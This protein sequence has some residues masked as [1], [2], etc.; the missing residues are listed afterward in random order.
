MSVMKRAFFFLLIALFLTFSLPQQAFSS[1]LEDDAVL[2]SPYEK[3]MYVAD[4][5]ESTGIPCTRHTDSSQENGCFPFNITVDIQGNIPR[6]KDREGQPAKTLI[7]SFTQDF[8]E[9]NPGFFLTLIERI[10]N[11]GL[12][13]S[14]TLLFSTE[15]ERESLPISSLTPCDT[16]LF[17]RLCYENDLY[18]SIV[19]I[20][21]TIIQGKILTTGGRKQSPLWIV[22]LIKNA[23]DGNGKKSRV[24][25]QF[26]HKA[27]HQSFRE[28]RRLSAFLE[29]DICAAGLPLGTST[30]D[31]D[32]LMEILNEYDPDMEQNWTSHYNCI[33][34]MGL[35]IW[36]NESFLALAFMVLSA[37]VLITI[38]FNSFS[39]STKNIATMQDIKRTFYF[40]PAYVAISVLSITICQLGFYFLRYRPMVYFLLKYGVSLVLI[41]AVIF[42]QILFRFKTSIDSFSFQSSIVAAVNIFIFAAID[43]SLMFTFIVDYALIYL[44]HKTKNKILSVILF[45]SILIPA[46][47]FLSTIGS[48]IKPEELGKLSIMSPRENLL[49]AMVFVPF[50]FQ[51]GRIVIL[52]QN[53]TRTIRPNSIAF[54]VLIAAIPTASV[55]IIMSALAL[56]TFAMDRFNNSRFNEIT[57]EVSDQKADEVTVRIISDSIFDL[58]LNRI[59]IIPHEGTKMIHCEAR[60]ISEN[61]IPLYDCNFNYTMESSHIARIEIPD[62]PEK[63]F[64]INFSSDSDAE[65]SIQLDVWSEKD[66]MIVHTYKNPVFSGKKEDDNART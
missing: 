40:S 29:N 60:I 54:K 12:G 66:G 33:S 30:L 6:E 56:G 13:Y 47:Y 59:T 37:L 27:K 61:G 65:I 19:I 44:M 63:E 48:S 7:L 26:F 14:C 45:V 39:Y 34:I 58:N 50:A 41:F 55:A 18:S 35:D 38:C 36:L 15:N 31:M 1:E 49:C 51:W 57:L 17:A 16:E 8:F 5:F 43:L 28:N 53:K 4:F 62:N 25:T 42:T 2:R 9:K 64:A 21:E 32:V 11:A 10:K 20:D 23:C 24:S 52:F 46:T 22:K 3:S